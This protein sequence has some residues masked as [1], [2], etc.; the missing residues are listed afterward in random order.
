[1]KYQ[2]S[3]FGSRAEFGE[4]IKKAIPDLFAGRLAV[5][6]KTVAI[7]S[8]LDLDYKIK[9]DEDDAGGSFTLKVA[10][11]NPNVEINLDE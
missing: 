11:E 8:D 3:N 4:Y 10:W 1:M 2:E 6:G 7:P 9:Y 5:E